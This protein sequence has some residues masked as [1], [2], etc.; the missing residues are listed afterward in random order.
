MSVVRRGL[1]QI[2]SCTNS[3]I[4]KIIL[5]RKRVR[6]SLGETSIAQIEKRLYLV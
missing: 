2:Y 3:R 5:I 4:M 1:C 6:Y